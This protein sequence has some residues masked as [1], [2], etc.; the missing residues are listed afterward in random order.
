MVD[1]EEEVQFIGK[2][3]PYLNENHKYPTAASHRSR[4][5]E[6]QYW[7][8]TK[9][10]S[11]KTRPPKSRYYPLRNKKQS[12]FTKGN[13][14]FYSHPKVA[15][16]MFGRRSSCVSCWYCIKK[17]PEPLKCVNSY[18]G[19]WKFGGFKRKAEVIFFFK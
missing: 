16:G 19:P 3:I 18:A 8:K 13:Q 5:V 14:S 7:G 17:D 11:V 12:D 2:T 15:G 10:E 9:A 6:R 4:L 1:L